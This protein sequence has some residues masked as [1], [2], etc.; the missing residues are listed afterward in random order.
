M[1]AVDEITII[2]VAPLGAPGTGVTSGQWTTIRADVDGLINA[3]PLTLNDLNLV[4]ITNPQAGQALVY[5]A[6]GAWTNV[7]TLEAVKYV[8]SGDATLVV[9]DAD[10]LNFLTTGLTVVQNGQRPTQADIGILYGTTSGTVAAGDHVHNATLQNHWDVAATG[11][12]SSGAR[13]LVSQSTTA[14]VAGVVYNCAA[15]LVVTG[16]NNVNS[17]TVTLSI[18]IGADTAHTREQQTV[19]GV[20]H[21]L[22]VEGE[23]TVTGTGAPLTV[24]A[25][26]SYS[27]G[28]PTD[29]RDGYIVFTA[30]PHR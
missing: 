19:G 21:E 18:K 1:A 10:R 26:V 25:T 13:T 12:L 7:T 30:W 2:Q 23:S 4:V 3:P 11:V 8:K 29:I 5:N 9:T 17:G 27:T 14:L 20:P 15:K 28:D 22:I 16:R 6:N 24:I